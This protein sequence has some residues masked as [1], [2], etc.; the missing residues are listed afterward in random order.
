[1]KKKRDDY[2]EMLDY[3]VNTLKKSG[4]NIEANKLEHE[5]SASFTSTELY[6]RSGS[7][8]MGFKSRIEITELIGNEIESFL[9]FCSKQGLHIKPGPR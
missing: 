3:I 9:N 2:L 8:L 6:L 7:I 4:Y 1:M 5:I